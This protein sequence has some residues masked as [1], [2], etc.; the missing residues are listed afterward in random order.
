MADAVVT[1][2]QSKFPRNELDK[3]AQ[4][5]TRLIKAFEALFMD[6]GKTLPDAIAS[7]TSDADSI[8]GQAIF[9]PPAQAPVPASAPDAAQVMAAASFSRPQPPAMPVNDG[10]SLILAGQ[11]F[12]A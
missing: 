7:S 3:L 6:V 9:A 11:I 1:Q 10:D 5:N 2:T 12:G 8:L 4:G